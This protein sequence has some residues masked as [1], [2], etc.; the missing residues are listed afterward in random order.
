MS[1]NMFYSE[2]YIFIKLIP[3]IRSSTYIT[4]KC[5]FNIINIFTSH[6]SWG[7][8]LTKS[9]GGHSNENIHKHNDK[10]KY[11]YK[12][13]QFNG[14]KSNRSCNFHAM[15]FLTT[16]EFFW[17]IMKRLYMQVHNLEYISQYFQDKKHFLMTWM[18]H[19]NHQIYWET[20]RIAQ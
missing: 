11:L 17:A 12:I 4:G 14:T 18:C 16:G 3:C 19:N 20:T 2:L 1:W 6:S 13:L 5:I 10:K 8:Y 15:D 9:R 7:I